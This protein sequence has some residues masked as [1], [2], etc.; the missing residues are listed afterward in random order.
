[1]FQNPNLR[2]KLIY[3]IPAIVILWSQYL[4]Y[5]VGPFYLT[6]TDPEMPYLLNGLNCAIL[7]FNRIGHIDHPGTPFQLI[8]G[9]FIRI[10]FLLF[11]QGPIVEDVISRPEFYL[12]AASVMLTI[13][14]A[15]IILWLGKIILRSGGH[16]FGAIILQTSVFLS[17]VLINIPIRYIPD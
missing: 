9:L 12:T 13:L 17:T 15:F 4:I 3:I 5:V 14:T 11:G 10:T 16:F 7:E 1:M 6:R 2:K 8:T